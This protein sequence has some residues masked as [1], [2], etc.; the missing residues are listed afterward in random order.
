MFA[1]ILRIK[2]RAVRRVDVVYDHTA[3]RWRI[4]AQTT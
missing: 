3:L 1:E 4:S 2:S